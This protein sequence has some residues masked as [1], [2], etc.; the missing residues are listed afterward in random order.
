MDSSGPKAAGRAIPA[1]FRPG[2]RERGIVGSSVVGLAEPITGKLHD[3]GTAREDLDGIRAADFTAKA[4]P[5]KVRIDLVASV[6]GVKNT[7]PM[8]PGT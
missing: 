5:W 6:R 8:L 1:G 7:R 2:R 4:F 3:A